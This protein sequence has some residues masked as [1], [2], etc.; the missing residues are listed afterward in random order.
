MHYDNVLGFIYRQLELYLNGAN[1][2]A[3]RADW[4]SMLPLAVSNHCLDLVSVVS[5]KFSCFFSDILQLE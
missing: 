4:S 3:R 5:T 2:F 1:I